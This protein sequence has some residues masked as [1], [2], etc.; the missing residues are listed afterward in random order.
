MY[1]YR[2][3]K[4]IGDCFRVVVGGGAF[5]LLG[6]GG[7]VFF[8]FLFVCFWWGQFLWTKSRLLVNF[9]N[10]TVL[11]GVPVISENK[12]AVKKKKKKTIEQT[13]IT[14]RRHITA[15]LWTASF[16]VPGLCPLWAESGVARTWRS[17]SSFTTQS[18]LHR[19][20]RRVREECWSLAKEGRALLMERRHCPS[21]KHCPALFWFEPCWSCCL[22]IVER[23]PVDRLVCGRIFQTLNGL[24][25]LSQLVRRCCLW[26][27]GVS[28]LEESSHWW[29]VHKCHFSKTLY[30]RRLRQSVPQ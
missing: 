1:A 22:Y 23:E 17:S 3:Y 2:N 25:Q 4:N 21:Q 29:I 16:A 19:G 26:V 15:A 7:C 24:E 9:L 30:W 14:K 8:L 12:P 28:V 10:Q 11:I 20:G 13:A 5:L 27:G 18:S 6:G